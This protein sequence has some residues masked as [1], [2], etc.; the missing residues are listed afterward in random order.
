MNTAPNTVV[1]QYL[2]TILPQP[3][4]NEYLGN[5]LELHPLVPPVWGLGG[6]LLMH[7]APTNYHREIPRPWPIV[8]PVTIRSTLSAHFLTHT[9]TFIVFVY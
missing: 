8:Y 2:T 9:I 6:C 7:I 1:E 3:L 5:I 4:L